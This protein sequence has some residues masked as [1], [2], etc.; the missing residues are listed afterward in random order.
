MSKDPVDV[1]QSG[2]EPFYKAD[3]AEAF[4]VW[5]TKRG[6]QMLLVLYFETYRK[7]DRSGSPRAAGPR[8]EDDEGDGRPL[9]DERE[10]AAEGGV[11]RDVEADAVMRRR[12]ATG[13]R[14]GSACSSRDPSA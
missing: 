13:S 4:D 6:K 8:D 3:E 1:A 11:R 5:R 14:R 12:D 9:H 10:G 7:K 2:L